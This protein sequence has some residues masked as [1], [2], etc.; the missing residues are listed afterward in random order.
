MNKDT[1]DMISD[2]VKPGAY[3]IGLEV[4]KKDGNI[5][6]SDGTLISSRDDK[7][8]GSEKIK[9]AAMRFNKRARK[10]DGL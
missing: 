10:N 7:E 8:I 5:I 3:G 6:L 1:I 2:L 9:L 4:I